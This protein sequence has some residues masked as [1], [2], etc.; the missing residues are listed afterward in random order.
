MQ[1]LNS[2]LV[3]QLWPAGLLK[4]KRRNLAYTGTLWEQSVG[5][6]ELSDCELSSPTDPCWIQNLCWAGAA[7]DTGLGGKAGT[8]CSY[9]ETEAAFIKTRFT[10]SAVPGGGGGAPAEDTGSQ[11]M[12]PNYPER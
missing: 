11:W 9:H 6:G 2:G 8:S 3:N 12:Q 10:T 7:E 4:W 5:V 1:G